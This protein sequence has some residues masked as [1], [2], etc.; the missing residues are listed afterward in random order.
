[1]YAGD[2][3]AAIWQLLPMNVAGGIYHYAGE[4]AVSWYDVAQRII[5]TAS[6]LNDRIAPRRVVRQS[7]AALALSAAR[8]VY[9]VLDSS[10][11][12][13]L[14]VAPSRL[15]EGINASLNALFKTGV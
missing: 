13:R 7:S 2:L 4:S 8:P 1:T 15:A 10:S 3:A 14:G 6:V 9:S 12:T 11:V 5:D